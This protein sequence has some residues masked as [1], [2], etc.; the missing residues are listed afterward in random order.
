MLAGQTLVVPAQVLPALQHFRGERSIAEIAEQLQGNLDQF[1]EL[2]KR[3]DE[4]GLLWGPTFERLE[5]K[6]KEKIQA[7]RAFPATASRSLGDTA[8]ACREALEDYFE[9]TEAPDL[10]GPAGGIVAPRF[11]GGLV[12]SKSEKIF[13]RMKKQQLIALLSPKNA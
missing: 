12:M 6:L 10:P 2:A 1:I 8:D 11:K 4:V 7:D 3:L 9:Q 13:S 5:T